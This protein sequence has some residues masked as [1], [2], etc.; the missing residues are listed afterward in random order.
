MQLDPR[1]VRALAWLVALA[2]AAAAVLSV[3]I[4]A[5]F[6]PGNG[7]PRGKASG[8]EHPL[9]GGSDTVP[10]GA[11]PAAPRSVP[12]SLLPDLI[13]AAP[14]EL[15][16]VDDGVTRTLRFSTTVANVGDGPLHL[17]GDYD[18]ATN[19]TTARQRIARNDGSSSDR[20]TGSFVWHPWH[21]HWHFEDFTVMEIW[22]YGDDGALRDLLMSTGKSTFCAIDSE[23]YD[24]ELPSAVEAPAF[25]TCGDGVQGISVGWSDTYGAEL[26]GQSLDIT[27]L[28]DGRYALRTLADPDDRIVERD[29]LNNDVVTFVAIAGDA[30]YALDAP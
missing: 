16:I 25:G 23:T 8:G 9:E 28:P 6:G 3:A 18:P 13:V 27:D 12:N 7:D 17:T 29:D 20:V 14:R 11:A 5:P 15:Y 2:G 22:A 10:D 24:L 4:Y 21:E 30:I 1:A 19:L 26:F